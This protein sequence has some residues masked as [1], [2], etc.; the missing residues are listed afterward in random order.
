MVLRG[1]RFR[2]ETAKP[3]INTFGE[4]SQFEFIAFTRK[5]K[6]K[7]VLKKV[8]QGDPVIEAFTK[9]TLIIG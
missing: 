7:P 8:T 9:T 5:G 6:A 2:G 4:G 1:G 3:V